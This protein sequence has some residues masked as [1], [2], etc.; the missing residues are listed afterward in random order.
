MLDKVIFSIHEYSCN[1]S[2][3]TEWTLMKFLTALSLEP[4]LI[5]LYLILILI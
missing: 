4:C 2:R 1:I 5:V 3:T